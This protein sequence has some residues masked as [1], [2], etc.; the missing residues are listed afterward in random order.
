MRL[1]IFGIFTLSLFLIS[2]AGWVFAWG[3]WGH[4]HIN[5]AAIFALPESMRLFF[6]NHADFITEESTI[7][8][9]RKYT[10]NDK[11]ENPRHFIDM[12]DYAFPAD[13]IPQNLKEL[14]EKFD[15]KTI[16]KY[17]ILPWYI[18]EMM[19]K[20]T[21]AFKKD[22]RNEILFI[23]GDLGHYI[24]DAHMPLHT[25]TNHD[26]QLT[27]QRGIHSFWEAQL[28][29]YFGKNYNFRVEEARYIPDISKA[30]WDIMNQSNKLA[31]SLLR[32]DRQTKA[33]FTEERLYKKN[34]SGQIEKNMFGKN[35]YS[36]EYANA[37]HTALNG[38]VEQQM[39]RS[40]QVLADFW[41]TAWVNAGKPDLSKLDSPDV[42]KRNSKAYKQELKLYRQGKMSG[43]L[44]DREY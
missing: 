34:A 18:Q 24:A 29:E 37:F 20:L 2:I 11:S 5:R 16:S 32:I 43:F 7:P 13:K 14:S 22:R 17:G 28:P 40:V 27:G 38:M 39:R 8:D 3:M 4:Q 35:V 1:R 9:L 26:G 36:D 31:D 21:E 44:P 12:E 15:E 6:Y 25:S 42:T 41:Y 33:G 19:G 10:L 30:T 23:A